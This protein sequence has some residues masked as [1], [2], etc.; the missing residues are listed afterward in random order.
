MAQAVGLRINGKI[1]APEGRKIGRVFRLRIFRPSG[2]ARFVSR[3]RTACAVGYGLLPLRGW[4]VAPMPSPA[5]DVVNLTHSYGER[6]ALDGLSLRVEPGE[7]FGLL[8]PNGSGKTTLFRIL[9]TLIP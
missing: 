9:S 7:I 3:C 8:G 1:Q 2:A 6:V 5:I 4:F